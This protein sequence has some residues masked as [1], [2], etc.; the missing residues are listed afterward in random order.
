MAAPQRLLSSSSTRSDH[1]YDFEYSTYD[2]SREEHGDLIP[3]Q[4]FPEADTILSVHGSYSFIDENFRKYTV[5]YIADVNGYR[6]N[7]IVSEPP[8]E[9]PIINPNALKSLVG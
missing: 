9:V 6:A 2:L 8:E 3:R 1:G 7:I 5:N 4:G